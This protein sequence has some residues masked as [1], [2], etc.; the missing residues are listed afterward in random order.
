[1]APVLWT[2]AIVPILLVVVSNGLIYICLYTYSDR[3]KNLAAKY[4]PEKKFSGRT[5]IVTGA[6]SGIGKAT[7]LELARR[8]KWVNLCH[9]VFVFTMLLHWVPLT[10]A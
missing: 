8:G 9:F 5:V 4:D 10:T 3:R 7:A 2:I 6:N 1:M